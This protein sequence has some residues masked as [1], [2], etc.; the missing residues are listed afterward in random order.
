MVALV[1]GQ[2]L[3]CQLSFFKPVS[4]TCGRDVCRRYDT[5]SLSI[6]PLNFSLCD[7]PNLPSI[8]CF[9]ASS[10]WFIGFIF[11]IS[12][13]RK[14][15]VFSMYATTGAYACHMDCPQP[16]MKSHRAGDV[17]V[18]LPIPLYLANRY[19]LPECV[20]FSSLANTFSS[21]FLCHVQVS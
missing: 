18:W 17:L 12:Q 4:Y 9:L 1:L 20:S 2:I 10:V 14:P 7:P 19:C 13:A 11:L 3:F 21:C 16:Q 6:P 8:H 5:Q 15:T